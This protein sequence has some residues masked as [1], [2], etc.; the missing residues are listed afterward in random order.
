MK[1][2]INTPPIYP[3][4]NPLKNHF[5]LKISLRTEDPAFLEKSSFPFSVIIDSDPL[6]RL[7]EGRFVT[8]AGSELKKVFLLVQKDQYSL[9][10]DEL[11]PVHN[12][13][14]DDYWQKAFT[15]YAAEKENPSLILLADQIGEREKLRPFQSL[16][17]CKL[18]QIFFPPP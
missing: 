17:F 3:Y 15:F 1:S 4:L 18:K 2:Y 9:V 10:R 13:D 12:R 14:I 7:L 11:W 5:P 6:A 16:F 8:D